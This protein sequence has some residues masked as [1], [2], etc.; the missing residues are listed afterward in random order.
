VGSGQEL[1]GEV[2]L[3]AE[4]GW[5][6]AE[7]HDVEEGQQLVRKVRLV[8]ALGC[9]KVER[10]R[11]TRYLVVPRWSRRSA[12]KGCVLGNRGYVRHRAPK[13][14]RG[15]SYPTSAH[16]PLNKTWQHPRPAPTLGQ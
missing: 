8:A 11:L 6:K 7:L 16:E 14:I 10:G 15:S 4:L 9:S 3:V 1:V 13:W 2:H 5:S 12:A